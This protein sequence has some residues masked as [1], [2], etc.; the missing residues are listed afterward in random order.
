MN[1]SR[2]TCSST[3]AL[4][5]CVDDKIY[6]FRSLPSFHVKKLKVAKHLI[7]KESYSG[8]HCQVRKLAR[9]NEDKVFIPSSFIYSFTYMLFTCLF[10]LYS[11]INWQ[12]EYQGDLIE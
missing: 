9:V 3:S 4:Y 11:L 10:I 7:N 6:Q 8:T 2:K 1:L 5:S 12:T